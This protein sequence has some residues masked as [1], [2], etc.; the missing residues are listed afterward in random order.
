MLMLTYHSRPVA[1]M[2]WVKVAE[3]ERL[4]GE[5]TEKHQR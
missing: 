4:A 3:A 1:V 2:T 5:W